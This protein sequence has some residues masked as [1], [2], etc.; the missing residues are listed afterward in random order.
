MKI[1]IL[2]AKIAVCAAFSST[3]ALSSETLCLKWGEK[4][5]VVSGA[6]TEW[7]GEALKVRY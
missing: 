3:S 6:K 2:A 4:Y 7:N 1:R 5:H